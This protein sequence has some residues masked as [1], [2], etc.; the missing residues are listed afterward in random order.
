MP[1]GWVAAFALQDNHVSQE[2]L[3]LLFGL[4]MLVAGW[5][6]Y[7]IVQHELARDKP[8]R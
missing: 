3:P 4:G 7:I 1:A 5:S 2:M 8:F 6:I